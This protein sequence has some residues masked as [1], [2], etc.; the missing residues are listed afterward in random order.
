MCEGLEKY[1]LQWTEKLVE[2]HKDGSYAPAA[3]LNKALANLK[4]TR[5]SERL[6]FPTSSFPNGLS[7]T[8]KIYGQEYPALLLQTISTLAADTDHLLM[9]KDEKKLVVEAQERL[10]RVWLR[11]ESEYHL[12]SDLAPNG[13]LEKEI[14]R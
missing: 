3:L 5:Q 9:H 8:S 13:P 6:A 7:D 4:A 12:L 2:K 1:Q 11:L 14:R 10:Y